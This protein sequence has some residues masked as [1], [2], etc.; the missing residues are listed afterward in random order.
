MADTTDLAGQLGAALDDGYAVERTLGEGGF[1][2]V[3]LERDLALNRNLAVKVLSPD[4][5][6]SKTVLDRFRR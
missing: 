5:I 6:A 1:A 2:V 4:M 3:F